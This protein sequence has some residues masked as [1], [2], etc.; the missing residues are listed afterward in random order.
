MKGILGFIEYIL[1]NLPFKGK[2]KIERAIRCIDRLKADLEDAVKTKNDELDI[3]SDKKKK[4]DERYR[5]KMENLNAKELDHK[6]DLEKAKKILN[7]AKKFLGED[8]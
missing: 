7:N 1:D 2:K 8:E 4:E 3:N 6:A 5:V